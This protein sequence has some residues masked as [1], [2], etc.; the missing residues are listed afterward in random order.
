MR[1]PW[2]SRKTLEARTAW[3]EDQLRKA[4]EAGKRLEMLIA[5]GLV[6]EGRLTVQ[7]EQA[8][9]EKKMLLDR[10]V[11]MLGA[12]ALYE[13]PV[14]V[15]PQLVVKEELPSAQGDAEPPRQTVDGL[16]DAYRAEL[17]KG[18]VDVAKCRPRV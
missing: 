11:Q 13:K 8:E 16:R 18:H 17:R 2:T 9:N 3:A 14:A 5:E 7:L 1:W 15:G 10:I 4:E 12:P 6:R